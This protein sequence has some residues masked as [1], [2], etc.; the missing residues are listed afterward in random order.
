L[1]LVVFWY[2]I[3]TMKPLVFLSFF[4]LFLFFP[5][6][7]KADNFSH[8]QIFEGYDPNTEILIK[9]KIKNVQILPENNFVV[10]D[11]EREG[12]I[13]KVILGPQWFVNEEKINIEPGEEVIIKGSKFFSEKG[14]PFILTNTLYSINKERIYYLRTKDFK[15]RWKKKKLRGF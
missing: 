11:L 1:W 7:V 8:L 14:G 13:Y 6:S 3:K 9:G 2:N 15:P 5:F 12:K 10:L 4:L